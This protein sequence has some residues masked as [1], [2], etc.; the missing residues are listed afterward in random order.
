MSYIDKLI[1]LYGAKPE[2]LPIHQKVHRFKTEEKAAKSMFDV[3]MTDRKEKAR[4]KKLG[5]L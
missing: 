2:S 3:L 1:A 5:L 4:A